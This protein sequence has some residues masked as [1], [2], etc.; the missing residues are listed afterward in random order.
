MA[1][2]GP[3]PALLLHEDTRRDR[4]Y[5]RFVHACMGSPPPTTFLRAVRKGYLSGPNQFPRLTPT[6]IRKH[7]PN[8]EATARGHL[9]RNPTAQPHDL[10]QTVSA[11]RRDHNK[12]LSQLGK[13]YKETPKTKKLPIF[14]PTNIPRS[15]TLHLDYTGRLPTRCSNGTLYFLVACWGSYIHFEPLSNLTGADTAV[16]MEAAVLF[17]R[18]QNVK[19]DT[20]RMDNQSSPEVRELATRLNLQWDLVSP[21]QKEPNRAERAIRTGKNHMVATRAGFHRDCPPT[22]LDRCLCQ[23]EMT[24]NVMHPFEY[25]PSVSAYHGLLGQRFDFARH[26]IAP[27]GAKVL[28]WDSPDTAFT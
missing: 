5:V 11:R 3:T 17:F 19:L 16:A 24:L 12:A 27:A 1:P 25:D 20:I 23:I 9:N 26:P 13:S 6:M 22:F 18:A 7:M 2:L 15:T 28:T 14:D 21:Y 8:S 4:D 10:S